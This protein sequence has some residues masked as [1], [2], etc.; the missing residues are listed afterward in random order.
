M[1]AW[2]TTGEGRGCQGQVGGVAGLVHDPTGRPE[3]GGEAF[4]MWRA[5]IRAIATPPAKGCDRGRP[6]ADQ[7]SPVLTAGDI[8]E[9]I[10][11]V[12]LALVP[13]AAMQRVRAGACAVLAG[14]AEVRSVH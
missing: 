2:R 3:G 9:V 7:T 8:P 12:R 1:A 14:K 5:G 11:A 13:A 10:D 4:Y 6:G